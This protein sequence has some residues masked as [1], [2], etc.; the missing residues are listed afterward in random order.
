MTKNKKWTPSEDAYLTQHYGKKSYQEIGDVLNRTRFSVE[1]RARRLKIIDNSKKYQFNEEYFSTIDTIE[2]AYWLG[3]IYADGYIIHNTK[4]R[5]YETAI[6]LHNRDE[7]HLKKFNNSIQGNLV[8]TN[9]ERVT[10]FSEYN[11][12]YNFKSSLIRVYSKKFTEYLMN[13]GLLPNKSNIETFPVLTNELFIYFLIGFF[14]GDGSITHNTTQRSR[15]KINF[16][17]INLKFL[18]FSSKCLTDLGISNSITIS[19]QGNENRATLY[20]LQ[21]KTMTSQ[22][23]F[24]TYYLKLG[25]TTL[26]R[27]RTIVK[28]LFNAL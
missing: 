22:K 23:K 16:V 21:I 26:N 9:R 28:N 20:Q 14:D 17:S 5:T 27:K 25:G 2:K 4:S 19:K 15:S 10:R 3:F 12:E 11:K 1:N 8:V 7:E 6:E 24:L 18:E 13:L